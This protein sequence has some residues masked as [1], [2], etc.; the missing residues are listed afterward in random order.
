MV[1][2]HIASIDDY[3]F[4]GVCVVVPQHVREHQKQEEVGFVNIRNLKINGVLHQFEYGSNFSVAAL[5]APFC[6]PD[7]VIFHEAYRTEYLKIYKELVKLGIPYVILPHGELSAEAQRKKWLKKKV[8]NLLLFGPFIRKAVA[9]QCLS[10]RECNATHFGKKKIVAP[11]GIYIPERKKESFRSE[12]VKFL[13]IGRLEVYIKG[14]DLM[15]DGVA[16]VADVMRQTGSKLYIYGPDLHGRY[17]EVEALIA[18]RGLNDIVIQ[19]HEISGEAKE[20]AL[21][22]ADV[23]MQTSRSEG[24]P[25]GILEAMGYGLPCLITAG[26]TLTGFVQEHDAGWACDTSAEG[27]AR[28]MELAISQSDQYANKSQNAR[29]AVS[30]YF[31]WE[32]VVEKT[33]HDYAQLIHKA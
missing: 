12:G 5:P 29:A 16:K 10:E 6:R 23:F 32:R 7:V 19:N 14:I 11:N 1:I 31:S 24:M 26:T 21:L 33:L 13:F 4:G 15:L 3:P 18:E 2:L 8:A 9:V 28:A 27:I 20:N 25:M 22:D 17:A 30:T